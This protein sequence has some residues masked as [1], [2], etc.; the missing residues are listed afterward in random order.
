MMA[1]IRVSLLVYMLS[2]FSAPGFGQER[3]PEPE[4][5]PE[6]DL[7]PGLPGLLE[8]LGEFVTRDGEWIDPALLEE[9]TLRRLG[10][11]SERGEGLGGVAAEVQDDD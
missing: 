8:F 3:E 1:L 6:D 10:G 2:L 7:M 9:N 5:L 11:L 4:S